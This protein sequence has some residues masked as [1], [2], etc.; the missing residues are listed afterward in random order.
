MLTRLVIAQTATLTGTIKDKKDNSELIGVNILIK[1]TSLGAVT[2]VNGTF[3]IKNIKP[4]EYD[5]EMT[6]IGYNK[7]LLTGIKLTAGQTKDLQVSL[8]PTT[9]TTEDVVIIGKKP[10]IDI[11]KAQSVHSIGQEA[12]E[13]APARQLQSIVNTQPGVIQSP[14]GVSI[15][16]GRTYET[17]V[18]VDG[19]KVTDPLGGTGFGLD[20]GSNAISDVDITTGGIG[21][22]VGDA[23]AGVINTKTRSG[24]D[25]FEVAANYKR[26]NY[27]FNKDY[28]SCWNT[29]VGELNVS[30]PLFKKPLASRLRFSVALR[31][32]FTDDYY[33]NPADQL[34][35][36]LY[37]DKNGKATMWAPYQD[38]RW[39]AFVKLNYQ[40]KGGKVLTV[41]QLRSLTVN[42][43]LNML[44]IFGNDLPFSPGYQYDFSQQMD[45]ANT[46]T[47]DSYLTS[48]NWKQFINKRFSYDATLSRLFVRLRADANGQP[49][50]PDVVV[51]QLD[52]QSINLYPATYFNPGDNIAYVNNPSGFYNNNGIATLWHDHYFVENALKAVGNYSS[53][54]SLNNLSF[55][56]EMKF[57][58]MQWIDIIRPWVGAPLPLPD[59][60][61]SQTYRLGQQSDI[62]KVD[63]QRG[64]FFVSDLIKYHGLI[65]SIGG[66]FE[67][68]APGKYVDDAVAN[69][70]APILD[71][72][73]QS[74]LDHT[75]KIGG[76]RYKFRFLPKLSA[77]FPIRENQMLYFNYGHTTI[78]PHPSYIYP[79]LNPYYQDRSTIANV[80]NPDLNP[81]VDISYEIGLKTQITSNDAL[82]FSAFWKDKYDFIT[83]TSVLIP[84][85][86][87][88]EVS[89]TM[90]INSA[91]ART[92]GIEINYVKRIGNWYNGQAGFTYMV[93]TGQSSSA[94]EA[95]KEILANGAAEDT[96]EF[97]LPWDC[98]YDFKTNHTF[99]IDRKTPPLGKKFL[100]QWSIYFETVL[101]SGVRYTPYNYAYD[102]PNTGRPIYVVSTNPNDK[103][104][105]VGEYWFWADMTITKW[106]RFGNT[107][108][109]LNLTVTNLFDNKNASIINPVTGRAY[110]YGDDVPDT[111]VDPRYNNPKQG[112]QG[113][114]PTNPARYLAQRHI[115]TGIAIKF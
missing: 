6:Y 35:S 58:Q 54:N 88:R 57:Q 25:K 115:V 67:Y 79:G 44:R 18:Y 90:R 29:Q 17:G 52:P 51:N 33:K 92:R 28:K 70:D 7:T 100:N 112:V 109:N 76:L 47:H 9:V 41:S 20:I 59:G 71:A 16:G 24:G 78:L 63:P 111:W 80:G 1:G 13:L 21:A 82:T 2:D 19:V 32:A 56:F 12:I 95:L 48:I 15:R 93:S 69:P 113:P 8:I 114:P 98:P 94:N 108:L 77:S 55:G 68:W 106:F 103:W 11:D 81:E 39:S 4:G 99:K 72:V 22:D 65:A 23:T 10:L 26:D 30:G 37:P 45:N 74:Y 14:A 38:N 3:A 34:H 42:Q 73:R 83:S 104:G 107:R 46:Y 75:T 84:D 96:R 60:T 66:R 43:D 89:R 86:T 105:K 5:V 40:F 50:R 36:S 49:W 27:G 85:A 53:K 64:G 110:E 62:W 97:Y 101:R 31:G 87:G 61:M 91:Y 102:D